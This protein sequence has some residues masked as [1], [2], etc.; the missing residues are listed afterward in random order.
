M[1]GHHLI[2]RSEVISYL[3]VFWHLKQSEIWWQWNVARGSITIQCIHWYWLEKKISKH[4][5]ATPVQHLMSI[6]GRIFSAHTLTTYF[7]RYVLSSKRPLLQLRFELLEVYS[8][9]IVMFRTIMCIIQIKYFRFFAYKHRNSYS[10]FSL[11]FVH[12]FEL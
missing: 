4:D 8:I 9:H 5:L 6:V 7:Y 11:N 2:R 1:C 12:P 10:Q 3:D